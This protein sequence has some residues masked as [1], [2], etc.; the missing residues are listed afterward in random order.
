M[1]KTYIIPEIPL[2]DNCFKG[3]ENV[4]QYRKEKKR[5]EELIFFYCRPKPRRPIEKSIVTITYFFR[6]KRRHDPDNY[7]GKFILDGLVKA[8]ILMD[9]SFFHIDLRLK[10]DYDKENPRTEVKVEEIQ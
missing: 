5:W 8:G 4:W 9:D 10:G 6:D 1:T 3:R 2:S 7:S